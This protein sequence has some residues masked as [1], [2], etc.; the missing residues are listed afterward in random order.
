M[1]FGMPFLVGSLLIPLNCVSNFVSEHSNT[2]FMRE[3]YAP[4]PAVSMPSLTSDDQFLIDVVM[5]LE[6]F[7]SVLKFVIVQLSRILLG[8]SFSFFLVIL[9]P[10]HL[11]SLVENLVG[12]EQESY[13]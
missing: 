1:A 12:V 6:A 3:Y 7:K 5:V 10:R 13:K 9:E 8:K 4:T 2:R 11:N